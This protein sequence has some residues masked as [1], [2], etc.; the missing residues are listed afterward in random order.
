[1]PVP[2][3][4]VDANWEIVGARDFDGDGATDLLWY[5]STSG[6][7]VQWLMDASVQRLTGR[8]TVPAQAGDAN[9]K[10]L[11][12]GDFGVGA[13]GV[14]GSNDVVWHN[15]SSGKLV[16]WYLDLA[17]NR[18]AGTFTTPDGP[19]APATDWTVAGPR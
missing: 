15:A 10:V 3:Q 4:A 8:F 1:M 11:A 7:I 2:A 13:G 9:W 18:T 12:A 5:N 14:A 6:K 19:P 17:G 16:V